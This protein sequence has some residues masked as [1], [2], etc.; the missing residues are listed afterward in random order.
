MKNKTS[1]L[2]N[3]DLNNLNDALRQLN[4]FMLHVGNAKSVGIDTEPFERQAAYY[5]DQLTRMKQ[6]YFPNNP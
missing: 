4:E 6:V 1:P 2:N 5:N 3:V